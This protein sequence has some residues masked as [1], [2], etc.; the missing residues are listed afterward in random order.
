M[1][2]SISIILI[3]SSVLFSP[4]GQAQNKKADKLYDKGVEAYN[5][6]NYRAA[7]SLFGLSAKIQPNRDVYYNLAIAKN[8]LG[9]QCGSCKYLE[10]ASNFGDDKSYE[11]FRKHC[12]I[13]DS[14]VFEDPAYYCLTEQTFCR[15]DISF[16]FYKRARKGADSIV[17]LKNE[18]LLTMEYILS[19]KFII[20]EN[21][22]TVLFSLNEIQPEF[23]GGEYALFEFLAR[24]IKYPI[25]ARE[26]NVQGTVF[27]SFVVEPDGKITN[28]RVVQGIGGGCDEEAIRVVSIMPSWK[29]GMQLNK[30]VRVQFTLPIRFMIGG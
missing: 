22:D 10:L 18:S 16:N 28:I 15:E 7:D 17:V 21:I 19:T 25:Y 6:E 9:D 3:I 8:K 14:I 2:T 11:L 29:P 30:P 1:K 4:Y 20:E 27:L 5:S 23:P 12:I 13:K 24:N 26:N